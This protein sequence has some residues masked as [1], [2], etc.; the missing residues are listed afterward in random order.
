MTVISKSQSL[1][2]L[3]EKISTAVQDKFGST[4]VNGKYTWVKDLFADKVVYSVDG[5]LYQ[6]SYSVLDNKVTFG[7]PVEVEIAYKT[8]GEAAR[9]MCAESD[10][11]AEG[12]YDANTGELTLTVI[13]PGFNK[14]K[15]R[16][17]PAAMLKRDYG[18]F[19]G[20]KMFADHQTDAES[21]AKPEGSV[22][23][24]VASIKKPWVE[25]DG[26]VKAKAA[27]I[28]PPFKAKLEEL[29]KQNLLH[30]MGV[31]IRAIGE[32]SP[33][34]VQGTKTNLVE[35]LV[36]ARSVDFVTYAG[37]GGQVEAIEANNDG[38]DVD[39]ITETQLRER[40]PDLIN[41]IES[42]AHKE[43]TKLKTLEQQ[44]Q[45]ATT[46][47]AAA[48]T[49]ATELETK[50]TESVATAKKAT[51]GAELSKLLTES[52]LPV[53]AQDRIRKQ[54][55]EAVEVTGMKEAIAEEKE[56][57]KSFG[58]AQTIRNMGAG[59]NGQEHNESDNGAGSE[60]K[61]NLEEAFNLLPGLS[62]EEAKIA[63]G[64]KR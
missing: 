4:G 20:A 12:S 29:N 34:E 28:D 49:K 51:A 40:R 36:R 56:Y 15:G 58:S 57:I 53:K 1:D 39:L 55:A 43:G 2:A 25:S 11:L 33:A 7:D 35:S 8:L 44:L 24:W 62:K 52:G 60:K 32:A 16:Y 5:C 38:T 54:F 10:Q 37:A 64:S 9:S 13:K 61:V 6:A 21:K 14:S 63:A 59:D 17:Y 22:N 31:S 45:E 19:E 42:N 3:R 50:L 18:I 23:N 46:A 30:E 27:V 48:N 47:L 26:T 41:I